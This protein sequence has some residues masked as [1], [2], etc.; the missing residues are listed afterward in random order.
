MIEKRIQIAQDNINE[1]NSYPEI[2]IKTIK[3]MFNAYDS[4]TPCGLKM[5]NMSGYENCEYNKVKYYTMLKGLLEK[6][7]ENI[8]INLPY[9]KSTIIGRSFIDYL[10]KKIEKIQSQIDKHKKKLSDPKSLTESLVEKKNNKLQS[11]GKKSTIKK[12]IKKSV[13][14]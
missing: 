11:G 12:N 14:K 1:S 5:F 10:D 7:L 13:K 8:S 2:Y 6:I 3:N 4:V 9:L